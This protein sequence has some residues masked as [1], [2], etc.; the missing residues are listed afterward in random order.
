MLQV[1][2]VPLLQLEWCTQGGGELYALT[3]QEH[4]WCTQEGLQEVVTVKLAEEQTTSVYQ[5]PHST[6]RP[7]Q[8]ELNL[9]EDF[10]M[11]LSTK[12]VMQ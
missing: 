7:I 10:C 8:L 11:E 9:T 1:P 5:K 2:Q 4:N 6:I 12:P 3:P